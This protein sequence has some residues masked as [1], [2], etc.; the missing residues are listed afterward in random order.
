MMLWNLVQDH[1]S[2][3]K[4]ALSPRFT[5]I[6]LLCNSAQRIYNG[7]RP[8]QCSWDAKLRLG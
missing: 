2:W 4:Q 7:F 8:D 1:H 3:L 5:Q 6:V